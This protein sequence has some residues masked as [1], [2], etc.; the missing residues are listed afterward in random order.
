MIS[1]KEREKNGSLLNCKGWH[2]EMVTACEYL[3]VMIINVKNRLGD[4]KQ[5]KESDDDQQQ[6]QLLRVKQDTFWLKRN[7]PRS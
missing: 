1:S 2:I 7:R 6:Q 3:G 5:S 4:H